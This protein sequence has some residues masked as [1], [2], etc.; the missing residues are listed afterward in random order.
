M[1]RFTVHAAWCYYPRSSASSCKPGRFD[2]PCRLPPPAAIDLEWSLQDVFGF[3]AHMFRKN[4]ITLVLCSQR[5]RMSTD[6]FPGNRNASKLYDVAIFVVQELLVSP[7][8]DLRFISKEVSETQLCIRRSLDV[9][10]YTE[11]YQYPKIRDAKVSGKCQNAK[12][13]SASPPGR[14]PF[15]ARHCPRDKRTQ[16]TL[17]TTS[18]FL[19]KTIKLG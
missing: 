16:G 1:Y 17:C 13:G 19:C 15:F 9:A 8:S 2:F 3:L 14:K 10:I 7:F 11:T 4:Y 18:K 5:Y 6:A 12:N